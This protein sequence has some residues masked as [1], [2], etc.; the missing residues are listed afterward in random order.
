MSSNVGMAKIVNENYKNN[1]Q[2]FVDRLE[3]MNVGKKVGLPIKGEGAPKI[4]N[5]KIQK[6]GM[7]YHFRG[8][9]GA[10]V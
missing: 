4:P 6:N 1:P 2:K 9:L 10:M 3:A 7:V 5:P 8:W